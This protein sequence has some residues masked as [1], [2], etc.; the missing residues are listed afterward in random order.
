MLLSSPAFSSFLNDLSANSVPASSTSPPSQAD[1]SIQQSQQQ[2]QQQLRKDVNPHQQQMQLQQDE[3]AQVGMVLMPETNMN[4]SAM[5]PINSW[6]IGMNYG[7]NAQVFSVTE[8]PEG[9]AADLLAGKSQDPVARF[10]TEGKDDRPSIEP[11]PSAQKVDDNAGKM[12]EEEAA[13]DDDVDFDE[14]DPAFALFVDTPTTTSAA[15]TSESQYQIFGSIGLEKAVARLD[16]IIEDS[17]SNSKDQSVD[18]EVMTRFLTICS[19]LDAASD[20]IARITSH[21]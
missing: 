17:S 10:L 19:S 12:V 9:P 18:S 1:A 16:L 2:Q 5:E 3:S 15:M 8:I 13:V 7:Y 21:L 14:S 20:R 6:G 11:I 4:F